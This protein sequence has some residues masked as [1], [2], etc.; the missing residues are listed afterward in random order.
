MIYKINDLYIDIMRQILRKFSLTVKFF[1]VK[2]LKVT[3]VQNYTLLK[4]RKKVFT[5]L[6]PKNIFKQI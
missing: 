1:I 4:I 3:L 5:R 2:D 6:Y